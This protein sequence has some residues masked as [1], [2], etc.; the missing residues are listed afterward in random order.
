MKSLI[1]PILAIT[2]VVSTLSL[3]NPSSASA[4]TI[5]NREVN[6]QERIYKGVQQGTISQSEYKNLEK[7]EARIEA[8]RRNYLSDGH[9]S[10]QEA[11]RLTREQNR[12]S[13]VIYRDRHN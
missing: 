10:R 6:Q 1:L 2:S 8:Q 13:N 7:R 5:Y 9:L 12:V 4:G 11:A 3:V